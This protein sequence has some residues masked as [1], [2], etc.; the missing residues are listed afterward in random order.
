MATF[1]SRA[2]VYNEAAR[3]SGK[4]NDSM[5]QA[6]TIIADKVVGALKL[7]K[8]GV[9]RSLFFGKKG[10]I[11]EFNAYLKQTTHSRELLL[12]D[13]KLRYAL[14]EKA[15]KRK[16]E[17]EKKSAKLQ[18]QQEKQ[19]KEKNLE[20][21]KK[22][23]E[24]MQALK[25]EL[26]ADKKQLFNL[27][28][29]LRIVGDLEKFDESEAA[30]LAKSYYAGDKLS[31]D[32]VKV[33]L[34]GMKRSA[35]LSSAL[36]EE[37][38]ISLADVLTRT[39]GDLSDKKLSASERK[40]KAQDMLNALTESGEFDEFSE[41]FRE[42]AMIL[43]KSKLTE[44][45]FDRLSSALETISGELNEAVSV[46]SEI[47]MYKKGVRAAGLTTEAYTNL[48]T[49]ILEAGANSSNAA[50]A[51]ASRVALSSIGG[52][53]VSA[54]TRKQITSII[55]ELDR[56]GS[57]TTSSQTLNA[58]NESVTAMVTNGEELTKNLQANNL[59]KVLE[60]NPQILSRFEAGGTTAGGVGIQLLGLG[61][62]DMI[63]EQMFGQS[64]SGKLGEIISKR[65]ERSLAEGVLGRAVE[66]TSNAISKV[67]SGTLSASIKGIKLLG[68]ESDQK[69]LIKSSK[70]FFSS[71]FSKALD[72][73]FWTSS[74]KGSF[75]MISSGITK[76]LG[77]PLLAVAVPLMAIGAA[78][79]SVTT[80]IGSLKAF[81]N[82]EDAS[83]W[84]SDGFDKLIFGTDANGN[85]KNTLGSF[86]AD[87]AGTP[88]DDYDKLQ[89]INNEIG[90]QTGIVNANSGSNSPAAQTKVSIATAKLEELAMQKQR[91]MSGLPAGVQK[92]AGIATQTQAE[93]SKSDG[94]GLG[95]AR[96]PRKTAAPKARSPLTDHAQAP[97]GIDDLGLAMTQAHLFQ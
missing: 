52:E 69:A 64:I 56:K 50:L 36:S 68:S 53:T 96:A 94:I 40:S 49:P 30:R 91:I 74:L 92:Q 70:E 20:R 58:I 5:Q 7:A 45:D 76:A 55:E 48:V 57:I 33:M 9:D 10:L 89:K 27:K 67:L 54:E 15:N 85:A 87:Q 83:N 59:G 65:L 28:Q 81:L 4:K 63:A 80:A 88:M 66:G 78:V 34:E 41:D 12:K 35:A 21:M 11:Q 42:A 19:D 6:G 47:E 22:R 37:A 24:V 38:V 3:Q 1:F 86:F 62:F 14:E 97:R 60:E 79:T 13:D 26:E 25:Q 93:L 29:K 16:Y 73:K 31:D 39:R 77:S 84:I 71:V 90:I 46:V 51:E 61:E 17:I 18:E 75:K 44:T 82:G 8:S 32:E 72:K 43:S 2:D 95:S 23:K